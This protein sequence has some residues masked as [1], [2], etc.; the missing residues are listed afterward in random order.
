[1]KKK[2]I[3][4]FFITI[5]ALLI[6]GGAVSATTINNNYYKYTIPNKYEESYKNVTD[7]SSYISYNA[8]EGDCYSTVRATA[9]KFSSSYLKP[10]TEKDMNNHMDSIKKVYEEN[11]S[12]TLTGIRVCNP[13]P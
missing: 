13:K 7:T 8:Y 5:A 1:M 11:E 10:Y 3:L 9:Y 4:S 2:I 6:M 12:S